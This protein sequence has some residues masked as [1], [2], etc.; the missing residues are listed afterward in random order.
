M[1]T[2]MKNVEFKETVSTND[3]DWKTQA[4]ELAGAK[5]PFVLVGFNY[6][7]HVGFYKQLVLRFE[8]ESRFDPN[9][10][11]AYFWKSNN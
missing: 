2:G 8:L 4:E 11:R 7:L 6:S 1:E 3:V 10:S 9:K 5:K